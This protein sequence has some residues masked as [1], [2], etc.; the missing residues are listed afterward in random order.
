MRLA[1]WRWRPRHRELSLIGRHCE[2]PPVPLILVAMSVK[3]QVLQAINRLPDDIDYRDAAD[4]IAFLAAMR[5][6][7]RDI[8]EGRLVTNEQMKARIGEMIG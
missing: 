7:E 4:E 5:E 3:D 2:F 8:E 1:Y 6:A